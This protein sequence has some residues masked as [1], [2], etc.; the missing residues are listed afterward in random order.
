MAEYPPIQPD[1]TST[2]ELPCDGINWNAELLERLQT[3]LHQAERPVRT[4]EKELPAL[5][6]EHGAAVYAE[7]I[8]LM[9][10]LRATSARYYSVPRPIPSYTMSCGRS[11]RA[12]ALRASITSLSPV[13]RRATSNRSASR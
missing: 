3:L 4:L 8:F 5:E 11:A 7:L 1:W 10:H 2:A 9:S 13:N 6:R 12:H